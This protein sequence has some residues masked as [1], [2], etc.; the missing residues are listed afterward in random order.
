MSIPTD[1]IADIVLHR[2]KIVTVDKDFS[3]K[4]AIAI[5]GDRIIR[6]GENRDTDRFMGVNTELIDLDGRTVVPGLIDGH[7]HMDREGLKFIQPS[8]AGAR[9]VEDI[10]KIIEK[11]VQKRKPGEWIVTM[12]FGEYPFYFGTETEDYFKEGRFPNR[13]DL[14][15]VSPDNPVYIRGI[16]FYW[17][18]SF[19]IVSIANSYALRIAG[20]DS[21]S[22]AP[23]DGL[24]IIKDEKTG[25][26]NGIFKEWNQ[27][28]TLEFTLMK[29]VPRFSHEDRV[30]GLKT[31]ME[32]YNAVGTTSV[33]EGHGISSDTFR[34]FKELWERDE[35]TVRSYLVH[36]PA[37]DSVSGSD[38][39]EALRDWAAFAGG[40]GFG[41][42]MLKVGGVWTSVGNPVTERIRSRERPYTAWAGFGVD[43][44]LPPER[45]SLYDL[46]LAAAK[47]GLRANAI[48]VTSEEL[49][50]HLAVLERV[51]A[52]VPIGHRRFVL[53]HLGFVNDAQQHRIKK[54]GII[55]TVIPLS[56]WMHGSERTE[57]V[58]EEEVINFMPFK[59]FSEKGINY[60]FCTDNK[61]INPL[62]AFSAAVSRRD[63]NTGD[64][65]VPEQKLSREEAIKALTINGAF[66]TF[67]EDIKGSLEAGKLADLIIL[68]DDILSCTEEKI[69]EIK[70]IKTIL[71]GRSVYSCDA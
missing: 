17:R 57:G 46:I 70:V 47:A 56:V 1:I 35:M 5:K 63:M 39:Q 2:G 32:R 60:V 59:S 55:P 23:Y 29:A 18:K 16:W 58:D 67:E 62:Q 41:N 13:W 51:D 8:L 40:K 65:I 30:N 64:V 34:A 11:E 69:D 54:L 3:I 9:S 38:I 43:Q 14:D 68:S 45:G 71:G 7:A 10:L 61:P 52:E 28:C 44:T 26:P 49:D 21:H 66:L 19:P 20:I 37:W 33:Y 25:E 50:E 36:S 24:E 27:P 15:S 12:P 42:E 53:Q 48:T 4:E 31:S 6:V 22:S